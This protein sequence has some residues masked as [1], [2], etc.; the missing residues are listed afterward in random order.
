MLLTQNPSFCLSYKKCEKT[1]VSHPFNKFTNFQLFC[2]TNDIPLF[3]NNENK[4][5]TRN[6]AGKMAVY[7]GYHYFPTLHHPLELELTTSALQTELYDKDE[8]DGIGIVEFF[9]GKNIFITGGT[10]LLGKAFIEKVLRSTS[11]GKIYILIKADDKGSARD[12]LDKEIISSELFKCLR[13]KHGDSLEEF[14]KEKLI[15]VVGNICEPNL[16]MDS[17]DALVIK[18]EVDVIIQSAASTTLNER[19]DILLDMNVNA[20]QRLMRFAKTCKH[21]KLFVH[22]STAYVNG[23]KEGLILEKP[24]M[25]GENGRKDNN[26]DEDNCTS[27]NS[28]PRLDLA[29]EISLAMKA[30]RASPEYDVAKDLKRLGQERA[31]LYGWYNAYHLTKAM[32]EMV[33]NEMRENTPLLIIRPTVIE[34]SYKEPCPGWIQGNRMFDPVIISY[35]KGQLPAFL[36][37]PQEHMDIIP[38]DIVVNSTIA[39]IA[40]HGST[41][42]KPQINVYHVASGVANPLRFSEFFEIIHKYFNSSSSKNNIRKIKCFND[43]NDF[44]KYTRDVISQVHGGAVKINGAVKRYKAKVMYAEQLCKMYEFIGFFQGRFHTGNTQK[45]LTEMSEEEQLDFEI[46]VKNIDWTKYFLEA[47][48]PG[49]EKYVLSGIKISA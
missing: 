4:Y 24:L 36:A 14:L 27:S 34:S 17:K 37:N 1:K 39:A 12:R 33:L 21:L 25:M 32:A 49:L 41:H 22:I 40:K 5:L 44:S 47:H 42:Y 23:R 46:D 11:V 20:P 19:Y 13:E 45:L 10:G 30:C 8:N 26:D 2:K 48:I 3:H 15:P 18:K 9:E 7:N 31:D 28:F 6:N 16:G 38:V 43:F 29:D 35:G